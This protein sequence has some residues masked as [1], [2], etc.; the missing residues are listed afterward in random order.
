LQKPQVIR[1]DLIDDLPN[2][3]LEF[4]PGAMKLLH[5]LQKFILI[6]YGICILC[7]VLIFL[8]SEACLRASVGFFLAFEIASLIKICI[9]SLAISLRSSFTK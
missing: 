9:L 3:I 1:I 7:F 5:F 8:A 6:S 4:I 2:R